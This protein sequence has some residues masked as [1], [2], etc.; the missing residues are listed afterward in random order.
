MNII[1]AK[2]ITKRF[3]S[4]TAVDNISFTV[5][6]GEIFGFLGP[7]G[8]GKTTTIRVLTGVLLP[9]SGRAIIGGIDMGENPIEAK[10]K[11]GGYPGDWQYLS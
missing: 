2:K 8:A 10:S 4:F 6:E 3:N 1:E 7:N 11:I 5:K 9:D